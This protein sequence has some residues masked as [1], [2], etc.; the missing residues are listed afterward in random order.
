MTAGRRLLERSLSRLG[1]MVA[2][3]V[4]TV[5]PALAL[6]LQQPVTDSAVWRDLRRELE[7]D[8]AIAGVSEGVAR[9]LERVGREGDERALVW[10]SYS[11]AR[12]GDLAALDAFWTRRMTERRDEIG[13]LAVL[14]VRAQVVGQKSFD[15]QTILKEWLYRVGKG[16]YDSCGGNCGN[17]KGGG[18]GNGN[19]NEGN[20]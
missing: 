20:G 10:M 1:L 6:G 18:G 5:T 19:G 3:V 15:R 16:N 2:A 13:M 7:Q 8:R 11:I 12:T 9:V 4:S 17:G 14:D